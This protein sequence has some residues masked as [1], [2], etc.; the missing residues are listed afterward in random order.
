MYSQ[1]YD[2]D[3]YSQDEFE[4]AYEFI[5]SGLV[6]GIIPDAEKCTIILG[7]QPGAGKSTFYQ[8]REDLENYVAINGD[9]FRRFHPH[10][11]DIVRTS[12][13]NYANRTQ[14]FCNQ[15]VE[16]LITELGSQGYSLII[17]G[18]LRNPDVPI[19][20]C[21]EL[22]GK[23]YQADLV[24]VACDA[25]KAWLATLARA[26]R[27]KEQRMAPRL[28]PIDIYN[29]TVH[30]IAKSMKVIEEKGCFNSITVVNRDGDT[31]YDSRTSGTTAAHVIEKELHL[32]NWDKK[33]P[34]F[35]Q[36]FLQKKIDILKTKLTKVHDDFGL[37]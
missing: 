18:T 8:M 9:D 21:E 13:E 20:T 19:K 35:E 23:G 4:K 14:D 10:Y 27:L 24:V 12:L 26:E 37:E 30:Q 5:K 1:N 31:L 15:V 32:E 6:A 17:E 16:R 33:L 2:A 7:G 29:N 25:E 34:E 11:K 36:D 22:K 28:V 3:Y